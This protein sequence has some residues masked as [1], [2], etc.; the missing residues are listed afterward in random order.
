MGMAQ[1]THG[2][3]GAPRKDDMNTTKST[4]VEARRGALIRQTETARRMAETS[5]KGRKPAAPNGAVIYEGPSA[6]DGAPI[7]I[8]VTGLR[9]A[10]TNRKTGDMCQTWILRADVDPIAALATDSDASICGACPLRGVLV[11]GKRTG[12]ACYVNVGQAP[13]SVWR[14]YKRGTYPRM[15]PVDVAPLLAGRAVRL[16]AYG[17]PAMAPVA[18]WQTL[19]SQARTWT[20]YTHQ[21]R[22]RPAFRDLC[23]A[24]ADTVADRRDARAQGWRAFYVV[25]RGAAFPSGAMECAATRARNPLQCADCGA[26]AGTRNGAVAG[27]VDVVIHAH[28]SGAGYVTGGE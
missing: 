25:P 15:A 17:D 6:F 18:M 5:T 14:A 12:R 1:S 24:S 28:G 26:C 27:A 23:M 22:T 7:V 9:G 21:W 11:N 20:G 2:A 10:S 13:L 19:I 4:A 16:G 3:T 8:I